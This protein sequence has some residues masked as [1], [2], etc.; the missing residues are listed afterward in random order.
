MFSSL[1]PLAV[2]EALEAYDTRKKEIVNMQV[3]RLQEKTNL[4]NGY[5]LSLVTKFVKLSSPLGL[6]EIPLI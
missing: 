5:E 3:G 2:H 1:V 6:T 4:I